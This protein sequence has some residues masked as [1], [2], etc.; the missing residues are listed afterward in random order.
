[1]YATRARVEE[2]GEVGDPE[3][4][5]VCHISTQRTAPRCGRV[6]RMAAL[7]LNTINP[8]VDSSGLS[9]CCRHGVTIKFVLD[10]QRNASSG[11]CRPPPRRR[12]EEAFLFTGNLFDSIQK[13]VAKLEGRIVEEG[14]GGT[15]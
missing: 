1:M 15:G 2:V 11:S 7:I 9:R 10:R 3:G 14:E 8:S 6:A 5:T 12:T 13:P 4:M